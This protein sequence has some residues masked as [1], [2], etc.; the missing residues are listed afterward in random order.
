VLRDIA[1]AEGDSFEITN[2]ELADRCRARRKA[3]SLDE[4]GVS[5]ALGVFRELGLVKGEGHGG[6]RRL[7]VVANP[8]KVDLESS[9][10][11]VEG[12]DELEE[13]VSFKQWVLGAGADELLER[14]NRPILPS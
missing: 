2:A 4:K 5:T 1:A 11:Y 13:F 3:C 6:Y 10:R 14:F 7:T 12:K 9:V 8:D